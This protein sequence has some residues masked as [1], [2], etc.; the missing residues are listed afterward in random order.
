MLAMEGARCW[1]VEAK[2]F[3]VLIK[4]GASGVRIFEKGK[5][6][7][8]SIFVRR[9]ELAWLVGALE[10]VADLIKP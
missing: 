4:G 10:E 3:E 1:S 5:K 8:T 9:D 6:K 7:T 2:A